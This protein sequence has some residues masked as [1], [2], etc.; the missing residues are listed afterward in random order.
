MRVTS[1]LLGDE[2]VALGAVHA[3]ISGVYGYP[4]TPSTEIF[5]AVHNFEKKSGVHAVWSTNEKVGYEE[6]LGMSFAGKRSMVTMK[7]VGLNVAADP[8]M[9]SAITG[10]NGGLVLAVADD[11]GMHS[12]QNEQDSRYFAHF[13]MIPV[14]EPGNQQEAY[15]MTMLALQL[16]EEL[17]VPVMLRLVTRLA[18]SRANVQVF[19]KPLEQNKLNPSDDWRKWTLLPVNARRNYLELTKAQE[20]FRKKSEESEYN[21]LTLVSGVKKGII[22]AGIATNYLFENIPADTNEFS[23]LIIKQYPVPAGKLRELVDSVDEIL[24]IEEGYPYIEE[25]LNGFLGLRDKKVRGKLSG[26][27]PRTGELNPDNVRKALGMELF[28]S[29]DQSQNLAMRPPQLCQGCPHADTYGALNEAM[30]YFPDGH[31]F[32][33]IGCYTLG[34]LPPYT[35]IESCVDMG[36][37][38]SMASGAAHAGI[39]PSVAVIG[40][41]TFT[42]SGMTPLLD[43]AHENTPITVFILDNSTVAMTGG[44]PTFGSGEGL[45]RIIRGFD[46]PDGHLLA[47]NPLP[48]DHAKNVEMIKRELEYDGLSVIVAQRICVEEIKRLRKKKAD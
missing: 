18:H 19:D 7:H 17:N 3:G 39:R 41:S 27:L 20:K 15:D 14:L 29:L 2:A 9:N 33:D 21:T 48:K 12:S 43:A 30:K 16:S 28:D 1:V 11:P 35:A 31:V 23:I 44:Q 46:I 37:S 6:A 26:D 34:A 22:V 24:V 25:H 8:F 36:A 38:I 13:A 40:D 45:L 5:E 42:H 4:G 10:V 47:I 32:S